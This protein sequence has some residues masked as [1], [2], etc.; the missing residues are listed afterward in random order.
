MG[1]VRAGSPRRGA[2][3]ACGAIVAIVSL[4]LIAC[5]DDDDD[6]SDVAQPAPAAESFPAASDSSLDRLIA[7]TGSS[8]LVVSPAGQTYTV[9]R[10]RFGFG[11]FT[12]D[13]EQVTDAEVAIYAA[14]GAS[15][16]A[17]GPFPA[18]IE[19]L[20]TDPA[21]TAR[22]TADDPDAAKVVYVADIAFD[23]PGEWRLLAV[24]R[25]G[26]ETSAVRLPSVEVRTE[27]SVPALGERAPRVHT[28]TVEDV[29]GNVA[30]IDT[31][32]PTG[33]MHDDDLA[34]VLGERPVVLLF[35]TPALCQSRVCG[36]VVDVAEQVKRDYG[37]DVAFIHMEIWRDNDPSKP[38]RPQV[39][40]YGL[41]TE[42][43]LFVIDRNGIVETQIEGAFSVAELT[44]AVERVT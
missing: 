20:E 27:T 8:E 29:G 12:V 35:A 33:T 11:V 37:D 21:F 14:A 42:P 4:V 41:Q 15:G 38:V 43:W 9:G 36:P 26:S 28:P 34:D 40:A 32:V 44:D 16:A 7:E 39:A 30:L 18:R 24:V 2:A 22:T 17:K 6:S 23:R 5:G 31:R 1:G 25:E 13:G 19:N 3:A 10:N